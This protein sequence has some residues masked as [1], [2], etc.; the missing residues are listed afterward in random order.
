MNRTFAKLGRPLLLLGVIV[1]WSSLAG[2]GVFGGGGPAKAANPPL[3]RALTQQERGND[4]AALEALTEAIE[5][6]P[7]LTAAHMAMGEIYQ[8]RGDYDLA[9]ARYEVAV[10][11]E[12]NNFRARYNYG[13]M[14][15]LVGQTEPAIRTYLQALSIDP[16]DFAANRDIASAYLQIGRPELALPYAKRAADLDPESQ[17]AWSNLAATHSLLGEYDEAIEAYRTANELGALADPVLLGLA[18]A[19]IRLGNFPRAINT[20]NSLIVSSPSATAYERLGFAQFK[21]RRYEDALGNYDRALGLD[22][23]EVAA[24]NGVGATYMTLFI[25]GGSENQDQRGRAIDAWRRSVAIDTDQ[26]RIVDLL[27]RYGRS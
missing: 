24:L 2:C 5:E 8:E 15:Q 17:A 22:T 13:L 27:V 6:N 12:P 7:R 23:D 3:A 20:L 19:H 10:S 14:Q 11:L 4:D 21:M 16:D 9:R 18:D 1:G 26:P 25:E